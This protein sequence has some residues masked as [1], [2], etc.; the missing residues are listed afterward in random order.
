MRIC[1]FSQQILP[2]Y[3]QYSDDPSFRTSYEFFE[4]ECEEQPDIRYNQ[5]IRVVG[6]NFPMIHFLLIADDSP[7][8]SLRTLSFTEIKKES[9]SSK[10]RKRLRTRSLYVLSSLE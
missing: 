2:L 3:R 1:G 4:V 10:E 5:G 7:R 8:C 6:F 9:K